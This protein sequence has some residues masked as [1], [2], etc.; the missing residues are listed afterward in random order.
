MK[1]NSKEE[2]ITQL[3]EKLEILVKN[4]GIFDFSAW[5]ISFICLCLRLTLFYCSD[6]KQHKILFFFYLNQKI[7]A[8][9]FLFYI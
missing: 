8:S 6:C 1:D 3:Q 7:F 9:Y 5:I 4:I 2:K